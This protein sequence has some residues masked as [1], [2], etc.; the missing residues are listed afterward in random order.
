MNDLLSPRLRAGYQEEF[1][2]IR[3]VRWDMVGLAAWSEGTRNGD[4]DDLLAGELFRCVKCLGDAAS[5]WVWVRD[6][7]QGPLANT[8]RAT[9]GVCGI[10]P[11][12]T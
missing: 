7:L 9:S 5:R 12:R 3:K 11:I 1:V 6:R 10:P 4:Q 2:E 8:L